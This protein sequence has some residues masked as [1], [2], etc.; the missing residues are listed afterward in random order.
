MTHVLAFLPTPALWT[1]LGAALTAATVAALVAWFSPKARKAMIA[2]SIGALGLVAIV[3][4]DLI[5]GFLERRKEQPPGRRITRADRKGEAA[6]L[7]VEAAEV[8]AAQEDAVPPER[9]EPPEMTELEKRA[10]E[11][12]IRRITGSRPMGGG[13]A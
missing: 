1:V 8:K 10:R 2:V 9:T 3:L 5:G 11:A 7:E 6:R 12:A 13:D 4:P